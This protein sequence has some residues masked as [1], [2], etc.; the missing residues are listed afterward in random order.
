MK[1]RK[2]PI[3]F[4]AMQFTEDTKSY[5]V[6]NV[7]GEDPIK[8]DMNGYF[9]QTP[10]GVKEVNVSDYIIKEPYHE[11]ISVFNTCKAGVF[12]DNYELIVDGKDQEKNR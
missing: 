11:K 1:Y 9:I 4:E 6:I 5:D 3:V 10:D 8:P 2:K 12:E 7:F